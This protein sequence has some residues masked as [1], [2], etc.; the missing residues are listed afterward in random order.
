MITIG[1]SSCFLYPDNARTV[2]SQKHLQYVE[3]D[4]MRWICKKDVLP[5]L[6]PDVED[7]V[8]GNILDQLDGVV[9]QGG[10]DI[11]PESYGEQPI[12]DWRG[13]SYRDEYELKIL[14]YAIR[15]SKPVLG[16]CRGFQLMNV[17]FGG[18]LYQDIPSQVPGSEVHRS[19]EQY[20]KINHPIQL[21]SGTLLERL[22]GDLRQPLVN[23]VHHQGIKALGKNLDV[24][25]RSADGFIEAFGYNKEP[26]GKVMG[27]QWHPEFS[28]TQMGKLLDEE[29]IFNVFYNYAKQNRNGN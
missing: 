14:D 10:T 11:S 6:I 18:S 4:M 21:V 22:Y 28:H 2:F 29:L 1:I 20:D 15:T 5:V 12:G 9:L 3:R 7:S 17:Y 23:T 27:V 8:L 16:I 25:A 19:A 24:Y 13:D 26:E